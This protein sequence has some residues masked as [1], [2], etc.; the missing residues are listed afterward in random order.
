[1]WEI[2]R[3]GKIGL[4]IFLE[5]TWNK[6][7]R[8]RNLKG[9]TN[10]YIHV[11]FGACQGFYSVACNFYNYTEKRTKIEN[12]NEWCGPGYL[13]YFIPDMI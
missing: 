12:D 8:E 3:R 4:I 6:G 10:S 7:N 1:M 11:P 5:E 9:F 2:G 13:S